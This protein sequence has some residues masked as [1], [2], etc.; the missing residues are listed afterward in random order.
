MSNKRSGKFLFTL[1][2]DVDTVSQKYSIDPHPEDIIQ[3]DSEKSSTKVTT[4][5]IDLNGDRRG[6]PETISFLDESKR[7]HIC[8]VSMIDFTSR[9]DVLLLR[10][11]CFWCRHPFETAP[12]GCP[13]HYV[14]NQAVKNYFS[15]ISKDNYTIKE[16]VTK[17]MCDRE[18]EQITIKE[19]DYYETDGVFCS[20]NCC[21]AFINDNKH[22]RMY[23]AS[24]QLI[25]K[26]YN[27]LHGTKSVI[28]VPARHW[29]MLESYGGHLN[30]IKFRDGFNK[31][32]YENHGKYRPP[33]FMPMGT[34]YEERYNF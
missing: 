29:R 17:Q 34:L 27:E 31:I 1:D 7:T 24:A 16:N 12:I 32:E 9:K 30:I 5:L 4:K 25:V 3:K 26:M 18:D 23:D 11:N 14:S 2:I 19:K 33:K 21:Q 8:Q 10:Y 13:I 20:F 22:N 15:Y 6:T 28:I